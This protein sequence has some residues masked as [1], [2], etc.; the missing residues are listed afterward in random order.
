MVPH[1]YLKK[2]ILIFNVAKNME[3]VL[4]NSMEMGKSELKTGGKKLGSV[5]I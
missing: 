1:S 4:V 5:I 2:L 3:M